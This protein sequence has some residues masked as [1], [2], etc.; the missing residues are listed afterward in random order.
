MSDECD[1]CHVW[2]EPLYCSNCMVVSCERCEHK[3]KECKWCGESPLCPEC[4][5]QDNH[6]C[7]EDEEDDD[8]P[9]D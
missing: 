8:A 7:D 4:L 3:M 9:T 2:I 5:P 6:I 1:F